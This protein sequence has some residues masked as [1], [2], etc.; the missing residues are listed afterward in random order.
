[1]NKLNLE[2]GQ[3]QVGQPLRWDVYS[4]Q[5]ELLLRKGNIVDTVHQLNE[6]IER[7]LFAEII[8]SAPKKVQQHVP[9]AVPEL[10]SVIRLLNETACRLGP[11]L[12]SLHLQTDA[13]NSIMAVAKE[14]IRATNLNPDIAL[15]SIF[16][17]H[18]VS[19]HAIRHSLNT[20]I[21]TI[22]VS[23]AM[24]K[25]DDDLA[26][27]VAAALTMN[28]GM[29]RQQNEY[30]TRSDALTEKEKQVIQQH[31]QESVKMLEQAGVNH[32]DWLSYVLHHHECEDGSGYPFGKTADA[33][34]QNAKIL[35]LSDIFCAKV[36]GRS[37][38]KPLLPN[39]ALRSMFVDEQAKVDKK[40]APYFIG[41][42]GLY[43]SGTSVKLQN[44]ELA[45][46][47]HKS[48]APQTPIVHSYIGPFGAPLAFPIKRDTSNKRFAVIQA[49]LLNDAPLCFSMQQIFGN[50]AAL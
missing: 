17:N 12:Y 22:L 45:I 25:P 47:T 48:H 44:G 2:S 32:S 27:L 6:L 41:A 4:D 29:L 28:L 36:T 24:K 42:I 15:A 35:A 3:I 49:I 50:E 38:R 21:I 14:V 1:M 18:A 9:A 40:L 31:P 20:A 23:K 5:G 16:L 34:P 10:P 43:P 30:Q 46:V 13:Q 33:I 37:Y 39:G 11:L 26:A 8:E 7:G 19:D